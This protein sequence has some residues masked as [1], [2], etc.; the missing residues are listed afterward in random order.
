MERHL[1]QE[2]QGSLCVVTTGEELSRELR[3]LVKLS[4]M[5]VHSWSVDVSRDSA[6]VTV[7]CDL[8]WRVR[9]HEHID[10]ALIDS[11]RNRADVERLR[12]QM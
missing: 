11:L 5:R 7:E 6:R 9:P 4:G 8:R 2:K 3:E 10:P 12:W 1:S